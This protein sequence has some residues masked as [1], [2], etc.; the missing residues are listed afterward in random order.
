[1]P[2]KERNPKTEF[3]KRLDLNLLRTLLL[4]CSKS[5]FVSQVSGGCHTLLGKMYGISSEGPF[6][7]Q[8]QIRKLEMFPCLPKKG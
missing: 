3:S 4:H 2:G 6:K 8:T 1:M 5:V 7:Q